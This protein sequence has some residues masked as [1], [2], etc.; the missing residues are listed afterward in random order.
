MLRVVL[1]ENRQAQVPHKDDVER[2]SP[3]TCSVGGKSHISKEELR[4]AGNLTITMAIPIA[5]S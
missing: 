2:I 5:V 1:P 4:E 3:G